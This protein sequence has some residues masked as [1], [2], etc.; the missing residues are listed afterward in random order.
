MGLLEETITKSLRKSAQAALL[1]QLRAY[2]MKKMIR[3]SLI[4]R[5]LFIAPMVPHWSTYEVLHQQPVG[6]AVIPFVSKQPN[7]LVTA[8]FL[9]R[10]VL[11]DSVLLP[12]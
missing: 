8:L 1:P 12:I 6:P 4:L 10:G 5:C 2:L 7:S 3:P 9:A 11:A